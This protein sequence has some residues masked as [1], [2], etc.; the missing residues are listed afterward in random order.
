[1]IKIKLKVLGTQSPY[2]TVGHNCPGFLIYDED[3]KVMLDCGSGSHSL[4]SFPIDLNNLS[5]IL[6]HLHRDHYNDIYNL[7]YSSFVFHNQKRIEMPIDVYMPATPREIYT[8]IV[9]EGNAFARY[10]CIDEDSELKIGNMDIS[11]CEMDHPVETY[12]VKVVNGGRIIVYTSDTSFS[13]KSKLVNF[14]QNADLL[15]CESSLLKSYGFPEINSHLTAQQA[16]IIAKE[17]NVKGLMLTHFWPEELPQRFVNEA[18]EV[19]DRVIAAEEGKVIDLP[20]LQCL[21]KDMR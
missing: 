6:S 21:E 3:S 2:N 12:A 11:F 18:K 5:V 9:N 15:I 1:M 8:D 19:F 4:L 14:A 10:S 20:K 13:A 17:A 16:A 7:Q